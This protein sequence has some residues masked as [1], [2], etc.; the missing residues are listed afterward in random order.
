MREMHIKQM[1]IVSHMEIIHTQNWCQLPLGVALTDKR[2]TVG[3]A[4]KKGFQWRFHPLVVLRQEHGQVSDNLT[5]DPRFR[6][7]TKA[8]MF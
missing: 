2:V 8:V 4:V 3:R 7:P 1:S 5:R 6:R